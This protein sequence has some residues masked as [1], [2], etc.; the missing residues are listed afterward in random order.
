VLDSLHQ[1][2]RAANH[3]SVL[4]ALPFPMGTGITTYLENGGE[5]KRAADIANH[6]DTRTT[7][8][9]D[10]HNKQMTIDDVSRIRNFGR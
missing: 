5:L 1:A 4:G 2:I 9:Y 8:L 7:R 3:L 10:R 6:A